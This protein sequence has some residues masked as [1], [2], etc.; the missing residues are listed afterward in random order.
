MAGEG[1]AY[2]TTILNYIAQAGIGIV[3]GIG[4]GAAFRPRH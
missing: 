3:I 4:I 2:T 1:Q